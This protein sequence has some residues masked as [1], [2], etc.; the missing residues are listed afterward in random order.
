MRRIFVLLTVAF[1]VVAAGCGYTNYEKRL[2]A[3][4]ARIK[5]E[6]RIDQ[7]LAP[8]ATGDFEKLSVYLR[9]PKGWTPSPLFAPEFAENSQYEDTFAPYFDLR[10]SFT[11]PPAAADATKKQA[12]EAPPASEMMRFLAR[13]KKEKTDAEKAEAPPEQPAVARGEFLTEVLQLIRGFYA[14][15][16]EGAVAEP[17][18]KEIWPR[19]NPK[20][21]IEYQRYKFNGSKNQLVHVY[22]FKDTQGTTEYDA[23]LIFEFPDGQASAAASDAVDLTLGTFAVGSRANRLFRGDSEESGEGASGAAGPAVA[24]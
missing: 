7:V 19:T 8:R 6:I 3:T 24:F 1:S 2:E 13:R 15:D 17:V 20:R 5:D 14:G 16:S 4:E 12:T 11:A 18:N 22:I 9:A 23:A 10:G 21:N